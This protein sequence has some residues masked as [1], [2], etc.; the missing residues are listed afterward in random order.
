LEALGG[1][2]GV[3]QCAFIKSD[4]TDSEYFATPLELGV[5]LDEPLL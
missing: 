2:A 3:V 1:K 4:V 5:S